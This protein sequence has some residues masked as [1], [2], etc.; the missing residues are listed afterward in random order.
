MDVSTA[1]LN[2]TLRK[3]VFIEH[4]EGFS[5][6]SRGKQYYRLNKSLYRLKQALQAWYKD[7]DAFLTALLVT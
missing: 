2:P 7:I 6:V 5:S 4:L 3:E 1:F